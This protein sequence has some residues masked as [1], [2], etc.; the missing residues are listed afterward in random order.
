MAEITDLEIVDVD[1]TTRWP[2]GMAPSAVNNAGR[3]DEGLLAR[4]FKDALEGDRDSTGSAN[5]YLV[6]A[7]R[8]ISAY[9]DGMRQGF[10]A[11]FAITGSATLDI[12]SVGAKTIKK[13]H[14]VNLASGD[15]EAN[16]YVEV[17]YSATDDVF[18][19]LSPT[20]LVQGGNLLLSG[21]TLS[22]T[23]TDGNILLD[24]NGTGTTRIADD[25]TIGSLTVAP[26]GTLHVHTA[27]AGAVAANSIADEIVA[28]NS[29][30]GGFSALVPDASFSYYMHGSPSDSNGAFTRFQQSTGL[31]TIGP[32]L[33]GGQLVFFTDNAVEAGRF[34]AN[35]TLFINDTANAKMTVGLTINQGANDDEILAFKSS[36]V[37]HP[38]TALAEADTYAVFDKVQATDGG[39][40]LKGYT[41]AGNHL[42]LR[43]LGRS[44][45][46]ADT[47]DT[48]SSTGIVDINAQV[49]DGGTGATAVADA[50][51]V[52]TVTNQA[53]ARF[54]VKGNGVLH[55]TN[56]TSGDGDLDGVA[57]DHED[58]IGLVRVHERTVH[59]GLGI[60][61]SKWDEQIRVNED[62]LK[63]LGVLSSEG[64]FYNMQRMNSLLGGAIWQVHTHERETR[65]LIEHLTDRIVLAEY[66]LAGT[67]SGTS[68]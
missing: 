25:V 32:A 29:D 17:V 63:R 36:D 5:A 20:A 39:L 55:A 54:L 42:A 37:A 56:V 64:H 52:L 2:E 34:D 19:M 3:A 23:D 66:K 16:Q 41:D 27:T 13:N 47:T 11:S 12:D 45:K 31:M 33:A 67:I 1:N 8:T 30:H 6:A 9:Y 50:G 28:E 21:N 53:L 18:Q 4:G 49:T 62:D 68:N 65:E 46:A 44:G 24:A 26:D 51:N 22:S 60:A 7:N 38:M 59:K 40:D 58:D 35:G 14:D 15:I 48:T 43:L 61:M 57:L 10:H